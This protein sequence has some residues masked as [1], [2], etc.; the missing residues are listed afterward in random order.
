M[1]LFF[2]TLILILVVA[3]LLPIWWFKQQ[4]EPFALLRADGVRK[5]LLQSE[6]VSDSM[7]FDEGVTYFSDRGGDVTATVLSWDDGNFHGL[8]DTF[9]HSPEVCLPVSG[10]TL[11]HSLPGRT[12]EID[13]QVFPVEGWAFSHR[14]FT[15]PLY[16]FKLVRSS[17]RRFPEVATGTRLIGAR[18]LLLKERRLSPSFEVLVGLVKGASNPDRAWDNFKRFMGENFHLASSSS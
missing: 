7:S 14:L 2:S 18:L 12:L 5:T 9:G 4:D 15:R 17:H 10:A 11:L 13:G 3:E 8:R 1:K 6:R 16:A